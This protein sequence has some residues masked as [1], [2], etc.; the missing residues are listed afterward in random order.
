MATLGKRAKARRN[1]EWTL[2]ALA[3]LVGAAVFAGGV[4]FTVMREKP[5]NAESF[6]PAAGPRG[7][8]VL[9]VDKTDPLNFTQ[10]QAFA[11]ILQEFIEKKVPQ[12]YLLS[13]FALGE[14]I[15]ETAAPLVELCNPGDGS[16]QTELTGNPEKARA[17]YRQRFSE[18]LLSLSESLVAARS[19]NA[20]PIFEMLQLVGINAFRKHGV[21]GE[22]RLVLMSDMLHNTKAFSMYKG[23]VDYAAFSAT[24]YG[25][26]VQAELPDVAVELH[27]L[28][29]NPQLQTKRNLAFWEA[30]F[31]KAGARV[32]SVRPLEG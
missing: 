5:L 10:K 9:L 21:Q 30:H 4:Y 3:V 31:S 1:K 28:M 29:T 22:R 24:D 13:V 20:S 2:G 12:G 17:K 26:R 32:V 18:P 6:C 7:H 16:N 19:A 15:T 14:D 11:V 8:Y 23:P 25:R 27:Y